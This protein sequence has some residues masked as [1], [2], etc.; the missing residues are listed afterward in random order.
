M[1]PNELKCH[2]SKS[3]EQKD[4]KSC[5]E[6]MDFQIR[7]TMFNTSDTKLDL[8]ISFKERKYVYRLYTVNELNVFLNKN[9]KNT[10]KRTFIVFSSFLCYNLTIYSKNPTFRSSP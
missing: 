10:N 2:Y 1:Q 5:N 8:P 3:I 7:E 9:G 4:E 6:S